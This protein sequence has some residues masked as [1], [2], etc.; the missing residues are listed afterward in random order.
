MA[1]LDLVY[2][3]LPLQRGP[4]RRDG[5]VPALLAISDGAPR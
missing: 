5:G 3:Q 4:G 1:A 2:L